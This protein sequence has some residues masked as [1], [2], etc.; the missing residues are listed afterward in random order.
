MFRW[1]RNNHDVA[2]VDKN[3]NKLSLLYENGSLIHE[4]ASSLSLS[5]YISKV[6][7]QISQA[8]VL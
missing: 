4:L 6:I 3:E 1:R 5:V 2:A 7:K 8:F